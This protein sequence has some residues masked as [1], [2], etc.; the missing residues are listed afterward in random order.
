MGPIH[1]TVQPDGVGRYPS[2]VESAV[3]FCCLE[4]LQNAYKHAEGARTISISLAN[5]DSL[6]FEV[7]DD[8]AG[9]DVDATPA[10]AGLT[11]MR[12]RLAA[13][14]GEVTLSSTAG[15]GTVVSGSVFLPPDE[16]PFRI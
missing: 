15:R 14:G 10:G 4:A 6:R 5:G 16:Q 11:N 2:E 7:S 1:A 8:G 12:D 13:I 9:F 3:Y